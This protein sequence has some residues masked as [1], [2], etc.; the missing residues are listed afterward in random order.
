MVELFC[1]DAYNEKQTTS[2]SV[3]P[4]LAELNAVMVASAGRCKGEEQRQEE[5]FGIY[6]A[7]IHKVESTTKLLATV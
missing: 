3:C 7:V 2:V 6:S 5:D 1:S 4:C